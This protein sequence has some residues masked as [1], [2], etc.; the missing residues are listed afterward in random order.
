MSGNLSLAIDARAKERQE[1]LTRALDRRR[2]DE[3]KRTTQLLDAFA[4]A[5]RAAINI[6]S[7]PQQLSF[8][9]LEPD[10]RQQLTADRTAWQERLDRL[11]AERAEELA[12]IRDRYASVEFLTFPAAVVHLVPAGLDR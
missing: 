9:D 2:D 12:R 11:P 8:A 1:S 3:A 4:E 7:T 6:D 10:E 5:L